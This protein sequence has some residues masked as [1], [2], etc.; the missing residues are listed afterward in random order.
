[1]TDRG[2]NLDHEGAGGAKDGVVFPLPEFCPTI[3][4]FRLD[5]EAIVPLQYLPLT[6]HSGRGVTGLPNV[7]EDGKAFERPG[8]S[9]QLPPNPDGLDVEGIRRFPDGRFL[10]VDEYGPSVVVASATGEVLVRYM[11]EGK[12]LAGAA[13]PVRPLLPAVFAHRRPN[14]GFENVALSRDGKTAYVTL[15]NPM[16]PPD[17]SAFAESRLVRTLRL[18]VSDPLAA[19]VTAEYLLILSPASEYPKAKKQNDLKL[20]DA[21]WVAPDRALMIERGPGLAR[22]VLVDYGGATDVL[23]R[24]EARGLDLERADASLAALKIRSARR[25]TVLSTSQLPRIDEDKLEGLAIMS[26]T[27]VAISNDNDFGIGDNARGTPSRV[28][29]VRLPES[30]P[31]GKP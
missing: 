9:A 19:R 1:M 23:A 15:E 17:D 24:P 29:Q 2:P 21:A 28:W 18:D 25:R 22:L 7:A 3:V 10:L 20:S 12:P 8:P 14:R 13:Y 31:A 26:A 27:S 11:P 16:G 5:R 4:R 30:L 6:D